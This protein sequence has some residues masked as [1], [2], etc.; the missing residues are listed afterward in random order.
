MFFFLFSKVETIQFQ[1][2]APGAAPLK[3]VTDKKVGD[4]SLLLNF[5]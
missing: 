1:G 5:K 2:A 3:Y 4:A